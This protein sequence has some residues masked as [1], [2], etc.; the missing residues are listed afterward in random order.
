MILILG[1][2]SDSIQI[3]KKIYENTEEFLFSTATE[4]GKGI[5][6]TFLEG[7]TIYGQMDFFELM[8]FCK[9]NNIKMII[10]GTHPYAELISKNAVKVSEILKLD[11]LRYE[12]PKSVLEFNTEEIIPCKDY[13]SAGRTADEKEGNI[14]ITTGIRQLERIVGQIKEQ[15]RVYVRV[16]PQS[17]QLIKLEGLGLKPDQIIAM[18]GPFSY[19]MNLILMREK[20]AAILIT[21]DSGAIGKTEEKLR[22]AKE[23]GVKVLM[24]QRPDICYPK[25]FYSIEEIMDYIRR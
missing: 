24:I 13:E 5:A 22:A 19:E 18:K 3:A 10:D 17:R 12:R 4:Y 16:L 1:G 11:Y 7:K 15:K 8:E 6:D 21:K 20:K 23:L 14:L 2:T 25:V 9:R